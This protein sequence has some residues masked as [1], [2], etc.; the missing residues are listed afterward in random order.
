M[1][2]LEADVIEGMII[3]ADQIIEILEAPR[4]LKHPRHQEHL[5]PATARVKDVL[6]NYF[7]RQGAAILEDIRPHIE[8]A[9]AMFEE[10]EDRAI[11]EAGEW[12]T[13]NG[14]PVL[15]GGDAADNAERVERAKKSAVRTDKV[16][17][18]IAERSEIVLAKALGIP[19]SGDNLAFDVRNDDVAIECK[20]LV[21]GKNER[22]SMGKAALGRK[23]AEQRAEGLKAYTVVVDRR[24]EYSS[25]I[26]HGA[27]VGDPLTGHATYYYKEGL[28]SWRLGSMTKVTIAEL[29][30][31][32]KP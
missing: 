11:Q 17:Q 20:T 22:I 27:K 16:S 21:N 10:A 3:V 8:H 6:A 19:K 26:G 5:A 30:E 4:G 24:A 25:R 15:I 2:Q 1:D 18:D 14:H 23:I 29:K 7:R 13:I 31:I 9:R 32:I 12:V 28:G